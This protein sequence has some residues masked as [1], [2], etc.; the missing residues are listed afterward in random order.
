MEDLIESVIDRDFL[1][2]VDAR[3][4]VSRLESVAPPCGSGL[5]CRR[6]GLEEGTCVPENTNG[7]FL[8]IL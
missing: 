8:R 4:I 7:Q 5:V 3:E 6:E 1:P 2:D